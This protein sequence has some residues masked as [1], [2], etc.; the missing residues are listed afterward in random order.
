MKAASLLHFTYSLPILM[1]SAGLSQQLFDPGR[2]GVMTKPEHPDDQQ[3]LPDLQ[4]DNQRGE[5]P[6]VDKGFNDF[7]NQLDAFMEKEKAGLRAAKSESGELQQQLDRFIDNLQ[8]QLDTYMDEHTEHEP[9]FAPMEMPV[10][11]EAAPV[12]ADS[13]PF[14]VSES[15]EVSDLSEALHGAGQP[16]AQRPEVQPAPNGQAV[17]KQQS[18]AGDHILS[19]LLIVVSCLIAVLAWVVWDQDLLIRSGL[20]QP[21]TVAKNSGNH[22]QTERAVVSD[23]LTAVQ[24]STKPANSVDQAETAQQQS[25]PEAVATATL[26]DSKQEAAAEHH[27]S[28]SV[29]SAARKISSADSGIALDKAPVSV[30]RQLPASSVPIQE[31]QVEPT[32][33][34]YAKAKVSAPA[35]PDQPASI[36]RS[37]ADDATDKPISELRVRAR[38]GNIR[39][40]P[41]LQ[42]KI[43]YKL[44]QG[45]V[46]TKLEERDG[47]YRVRLRNGNIAWAFHSIF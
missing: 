17:A 5:R 8:G 1:P 6:Q 3:P 15:E 47:W 16:A 18:T 44:K 19:R 26:S 33:V 27:A 7:E 14:T 4:P 20:M 35:I 9:P 10:Q 23:H 2:M 13:A 38:I 28:V 40:E 11:A 29:N 30:D 12:S 39:S 34:E 36:A 45:A 32:A 37:S 31:K 25:T 46:V 22:E 24:E 42:G 21:E 43:L 41:S